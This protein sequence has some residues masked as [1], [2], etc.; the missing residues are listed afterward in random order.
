[1]TK[2]YMTDNKFATYRRLDASELTFWD[3]PNYTNRLTKD[4]PKIVVSF[5]AFLV[6]GG[7]VAIQVDWSMTFKLGEKATWGQAKV[8]FPK[9]LPQALK[10]KDLYLSSKGVGKRTIENPVTGIL[11]QK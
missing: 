8:D 3:A 11:P 5:Q 6:V 2:P 1:M 9:A 7:K 4:Y 10:E